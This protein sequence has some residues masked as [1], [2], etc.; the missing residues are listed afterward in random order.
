[1]NVYGFT[2][3]EAFLRQTPK[4]PDYTEALRLAIC[5]LAFC[6]VATMITFWP[7]AYKAD[8]EQIPTTHQQ[9]APIMHVTPKQIAGTI[10][11]MCVQT[12]KDHSL[13]HESMSEATK[14][15]CNA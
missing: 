1:M 10:E 3:G 4:E 13:T 9:R 15:L 6:V 12:I 11:A 7:K 5:A 8:A 2:H 14:Q